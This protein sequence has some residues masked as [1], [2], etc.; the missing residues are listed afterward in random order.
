MTFVRRVS[1]IPINAI[2]SANSGYAQT[3]A[4][5]E[6]IL[7]TRLGV[8]LSPS[9]LDINSTTSATLD[10]SIKGT[11]PKP[12]VDKVTQ[13]VRTGSG[14]SLH[15]IDQAL[16]GTPMAGLGA[17][18]KAAENT[19]GVNAYFLSSLAA[20]ESDYGRSAIATDKHNLF[21]FTAYDSN[22]YQSA[23][24]YGSVEESI[25]DA[26]AYLAE[27][28]LTPG[29]KYFKGYSIADIGESYA[30]DPQWAQKVIRHLNQQ[31]ENK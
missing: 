7:T 29:G 28:Y 24:S 15:S 25:F 17:A 9:T 4:R 8:S 31:M 22:P 23:K 10:T 14:D 11:M 27:Q 16:Q 21:G 6:E 12:S 19:Y 20:H 2:N 18:F 26:A 3:K 30:T 13:D 1:H 5:F